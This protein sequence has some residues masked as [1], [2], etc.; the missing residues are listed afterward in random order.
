MECHDAVRSDP[1]P[2]A[3]I[4]KLYV[5]LGRYPRQLSQLEYSMR[6]DVQGVP[7]F[8]FVSVRCDPLDPSVLFVSNQ[9]ST[10]QWV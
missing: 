9:E 2:S 1:C 6:F 7:L 8:L 5:L 4:V 3:H 10:L